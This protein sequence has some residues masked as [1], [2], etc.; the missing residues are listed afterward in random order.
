[1]T[2]LIPFA[3]TPGPQCRQA[4]RQ[5]QL[6]H[7]EH[8]LQHLVPRPFASASPDDLTPLHERIHAQALGLLGQDGLYPW[9][10]RDAHARNLTALHGLDG[11]AWITPCHWQVHADHV[12]MQDPVHLALTTED[13][14]TLW[15]A[16]EPY[17][18]EDGITLFA[19]TLPQPASC[20]LAHGA[21]FRDLPTASI[22]RVAHQAI[23][24]KIPRQ[25]EAQALRRL[26]S[27]MQMLLYTLPLNDQRERYKLPSINS[28]WVSGTGTLDSSSATAS[29]F[30]ISTALRSAALQDDA[31]QW[32]AAWQRLDETLM[33]D[34]LQ[35]WLRKEPVELILCSDHRAIQLNS[36]ETH[37]WQR[38]TR[39][40]RKQ[41]AAALLKAL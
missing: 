41:Q 14:A 12:H 1:M 19:Q 6:P 40:L 25:P 29:H 28:F 38:W 4:L 10:A 27:E 35:R 8:L 26:Q 30:Q 21:V 39:R 20:W 17:F 33:A 34:A 23:D 5:L 2:I 36:A 16:M 3:A 13:Y 9:A 15:A 18:A 37:L 11:W 7:L 32:T 22:D 31:A 24:D